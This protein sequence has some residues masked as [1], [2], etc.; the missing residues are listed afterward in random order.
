M[1]TMDKL[2]LDARVARLE[3]TVTALV[4]GLC[5]V[6]L[7][8]GGLFLFAL[9]AV[10]RHNPPPA[11]AAPPAIVTPAPAP[12]PTDR[13]PEPGS[14][15]ALE[16]RLAT[17]DELR[18]RGIISDADMKAS[19]DKLLEAPLT[20]VDLRSDLE[21]VDQLR[22]RS[23]LSGEESNRIKAKILEIGE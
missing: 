18:S 6:G 2:D 5:L 10:G 1:D 20:V 7:L 21:T 4:A 16:Q 23:L 17:M 3:R 11:L 8:I 13:R 14:V 19:K 15:S 12:F 22:T 9:V